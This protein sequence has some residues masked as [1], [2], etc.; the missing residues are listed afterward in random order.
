MGMVQKFCERVIL[1]HEGRVVCD[2]VPEKTIEAYHIVLYGRESS[3]V[4]QKGLEAH[5]IENQYVQTTEIPS[6]DQ[7]KSIEETVEAVNLQFPRYQ[8][9]G[10]FE[11]EITDVLIKSE[12]GKET[13]TFISGEMISISLHIRF[14]QDIENPT[15]GM[16]ITRFDNGSGILIYNTNT[17]WRDIKIGFLKNGMEFEVHFNQRVCL[18]EGEYHLTIGIGN[19][20]ASRVYDLHENLKSFQIMR[21]AF[22]WEGMVDLNSQIIILK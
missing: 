3:P 16:M 19:T 17:L 13:D 1:L 21:G 2:D 9:Y 8:R 11:A 6:E 20:D 5:E 4:F 10:T 15:V 18:P 22:R 7:E 14:H 12:E